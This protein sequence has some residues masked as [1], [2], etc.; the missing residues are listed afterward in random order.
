M[1][2]RRSSHLVVAILAVALIQ[3]ISARADATCGN[4]PDSR[5]NTLIKLLA[6]PPCDDCDETK[7]EIKELMQMQEA[8]TPAEQEHAKADIT[9]SIPRFL[10]G[11]NIRRAR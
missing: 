1:P 5:L 7:A 8:R 4:V 11:G 3:V 6:P 9:I 10:E 2:P